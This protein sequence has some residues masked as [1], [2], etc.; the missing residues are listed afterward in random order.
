MPQGVFAAQP[1]D[2]RK[3]FI[4]QL[5][6]LLKRTSSPRLG[7]D[8]SSTAV[9]LLELSKSGGR[10][11][12]ESYAV[13]PLPPNSVVEKSVTD[14]EAVGEAIRRAVKRS[15][16]R[17]KEAAVAVA[18]SSVIT[19]VIPM[20]ATLSDSELEAQIELE[21]DQ[22]IPYPLDEVNT[23]F[24]VLGPSEK[25]PDTVDVLLAASRS[26]NVE[27]RVAAVEAGGLSAKVVDIEAYA[28]E[29][30]FSLLADQ[31][32]DQGIERTI[33]V[34]DVGATMTT[35]NVLHDLKIIYTRD[36]V[37]GGKQLTE[38][39]M[40]RYGLSYEEAGMAKRQGGLPDNYLTEV[41]EPFKEAMAQQVSRSLQFFFSS[42]QYSSIDQ[43][44]LAGGSASIPGVEELIHQTIG[45]ET[46]IANPFAS[47]SLASRVKPQ[48]LSNDAPALMIAC[49]L[50]LRSFD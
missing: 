45:I 30:A 50:A 10:Y 9:K 22:Y 33:A 4:V 36:Q 25:N 47:M 32:P 46:I 48:T 23:D 15:G 28:L 40:R 26:E 13:E 42:S 43:I 14:A 1:T 24:Q 16:T 38:E 3:E 20:P 41:L 29:N 39:I 27:M 12:V 49:G 44:V 6:H 19:K 21:A 37:F 18:G 5:A 17:A 31:I 2:K 7:L 8:I 34:V 11:R 35:L